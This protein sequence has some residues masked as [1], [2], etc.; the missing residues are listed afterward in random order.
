MASLYTRMNLINIGVIQSNNPNFDVDT[1]TIFQAELLIGPNI[2]NTNIYN[3]IADLKQDGWKIREILEFLNAY[4]HEIE[5]WDVEHRVGSVEID[6]IITHYT[7][8]LHEDQVTQHNNNVNYNEE[9][10]IDFQEG[11]STEYYFTVEE[12]QQEETII[13]D[14]ETIIDEVETIIDDDIYAKN[15][16][17]IL[18]ILQDLDWSIEKIVS[19]LEVYLKDIIYENLQDYNE[20]HEIMQHYKDQL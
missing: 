10:T 1:D 9:E 2:F 11:D 3:T 15:I 8:L 19:F 16:R 14:V 4:R 7:S 18:C 20:L 12:E 5:M 17:N 6:N 13:D